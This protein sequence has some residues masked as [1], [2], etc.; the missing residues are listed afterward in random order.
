MNMLFDNPR[1]DYNKNHYKVVHAIICGCTILT[2]TTK[3]GLSHSEN[4]V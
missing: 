3:K 1:K 2:S 4:S